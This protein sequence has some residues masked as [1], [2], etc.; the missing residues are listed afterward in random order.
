M[1]RSVFVVVEKQ[2]QFVLFPLATQSGFV[3]LQFVTELPLEDCGKEGGAEREVYTWQ[4]KR[5]VTD[6]Q[7]G[8][9]GT[10]WNERRTP[11]GCQVMWVA[12]LG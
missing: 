2:H 9:E 1:Q 11:T 3:Q 5:V 6:A 10:E 8:H 7:I 12:H 4:S